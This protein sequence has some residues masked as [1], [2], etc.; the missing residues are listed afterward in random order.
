MMVYV[1]RE[2]CE[3]IIET[4]VFAFFSENLEKKEMAI[5]EREMPLK[6]LMEK[7]AEER[8][9]AERNSKPLCNYTYRY[10]QVYVISR[11]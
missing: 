8:L 1:V 2:S 3:H 6:Y 4:D 9:V 11:N 10:S 7:R 5:Q